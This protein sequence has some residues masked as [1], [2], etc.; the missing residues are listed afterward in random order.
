M[1]NSEWCTYIRIYGYIQLYLCVGM[2]INWG[3]GGLPSRHSPRPSPVMPSLKKTPNTAARAAVYICLYTQRHI[4]IEAYTHNAHI[5]AHARTSFHDVF[6]CKAPALPAAY[7][8][9]ASLVTFEF[10]NF[11]YSTARLEYQLLYQWHSFVGVVSI[12]VVDSTNY[13]GQVSSASA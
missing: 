8:T 4:R 9:S 11:G 12:E 2:Y 1:Y 13:T 6:T 5:H 3:G 7:T 10:R